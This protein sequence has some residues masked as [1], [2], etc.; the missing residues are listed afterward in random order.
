MEISILREQLCNIFL[1]AN[2]VAYLLPI[3]SLADIPKDDPAEFFKD[4]N[5]KFL[6]YKKMRASHRQS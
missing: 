1:C 4:V 6:S 5:G 2:D 3:L